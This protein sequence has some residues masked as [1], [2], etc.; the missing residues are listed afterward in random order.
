M[1]NLVPY[2]E[3][4]VN[5]LVD[6]V[7]LLL[8]TNYETTQL[9]LKAPT[10]SGKTIMTAELLRRLANE[11]L[12]G[13][14]AYIWA[15]MN[16]LHLQSKAKLAAYLRD[17]KYNMLGLEELSA[18]ALPANTIVF[19]NWESMIKTKKETGEWS[20][21][22][23]RKGEDARNIIDILE[24][25][26]AEGREVVL[27]VDEAHQTYLGPKSQKLVAEVIRPKLTLEVSATPLLKP[28]GE[29][30]SENRARIVT[31][32]FSDVVASGLIKQETRI[33]FEIA[34]HLNE[35]SS[36]EAVIEGALERRTVLEKLYAVQGSDIKPLVLIQL[37]TEDSEKTSALDQTVRS[38]VE[39]FLANKGITYD[40]QRLG[41]WLSEEKHNLDG[42]EKET[43]PVEVLIFKKAIATGWDCP[44]A[45]ILVM[46]HDMKSEVFKIQT[47]GRILRMPE[48]HHYTD[49]ELNAAYVYTNLGN[50][51]VDK[52]DTDAKGFFAVNY[53][54]IRPEIIN[55]ELASVYLHR[56]D[57][58]DLTAAFRPILLKNLDDFFKITSSDSKEERYQKM[59]EVLELYPEELVKPILSDVTVQNLDEIDKANV[60]VLKADMDT[61]HI[62]YLFQYLL[63]GWTAPYNF[64]R[65]IERLKPALYDW[66]GRAGYGRD[67]ISEVQRILVCSEVNQNFFTAILSNAKK[68]FEQTRTQEVA[69]KRAVTEATFSVPASDQYSETSVRFASQKHALQPL[70]VH[71]NRPDTEARFEQR[72]DT[73]PTVDWW[74]K[75]GEKL[76]QYFAIPYETMDER[77]GA[78]TMGGFYPDYIVRFQN[79]TV[80]VYDTKS[81]ITLSSP[82]TKQKA[83]ALAAYIDK[84]SS[85]EQK[86]VGGII[87]ARGDGT[88]WL[89]SGAGYDAGNSGQWQPL[90]L[91]HQ[92]T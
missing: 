11:E 43:S 9:V 44:R 59:D 92:G 36:D 72:L 21:K 53:A 63:K 27:I 66:F 73:N 33:N 83:E 8:R 4:A 26:R 51:I 58:H 18:D 15:S 71:A 24:A 76:T 50:I 68:E 74:Y 56:T 49:A 38:R 14:Y 20:N 45:Q 25:T 88:F 30:V 67:R 22:A 85:N 84:N 90:V 47:V 86:L 40:N 7:R 32:R 28:S 6:A 91:E 75:N 54:Y 12:P 60:K 19:A 39:G 3:E 17:S 48:A 69:S 87:D 64:T 65:S 62:E 77:T 16:K 10:G 42:I 70:F 82:D 55:V 13:E 1:I 80:G 23:V 5:S 2:Q 29:D 81:G 34:A 89:A 61:A 41:L 46:L 35:H 31:V 78:K 37:P 57:Y 52:D 79:G